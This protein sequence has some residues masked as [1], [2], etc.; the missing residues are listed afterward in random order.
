MQ[1]P[2][3]A[4]QRLI[5]ILAQHPDAFM[6][7]ADR[8]KA[9]D[10]ADPIYRLS[11]EE[12]RDI[13]LDGGHITVSDLIERVD[14]RAGRS[15]AVE[16]YKAL[17]E[18][19]SPAMAEGSLRRVLTSSRKRFLSRELA[20]LHEEVSRTD[21]LDGIFQRMLQVATEGRDVKGQVFDGQAAGDLFEQHQA[22]RRER[23][24]SI[25][26]FRT[27]FPAVD[28]H[29]GG[30]VPGRLTII[31][32]ASGHGKTAMVCNWLASISIRD[33]VPG[34]FASL[35][36]APRDVLDRMIAILSGAT[37]DTIKLGAV[38]SIIYQAIE[39][40]RAGALH[41]SD[42]YPRQIADVIFLA[43]RYSRT[44]GIRIFALDYAGELVRDTAPR[45]E[46]RDERFARWVKLVR[47]AAKRLSFHALV[48]CQ[49]NHEG[50]LA[51][52]K[53]MAH[54]AD[55]HLHFE[56][57]GSRHVLECRKNRF[58]PAGYRYAI[59]FNRDT[60]QMFEEGIERD[61]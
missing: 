43:E 39:D 57:Q 48:L 19:I 40:Y 27:G 33:K 3:E 6:Q 56:R 23:K 47:D 46:G 51:E 26:G 8:L 1:H 36:M 10:F 15:C 11:Y 17:E 50:L 49:V 61:A 13:Y 2:L 18:G 5:G 21:D 20:V 14:A 55:A 60:Q 45:D 24:S 9:E 25:E 53:K 42:N 30:L 16:L 32:G 59:R 34:F 22:E 44:H 28:A 41:I 31:S 35:E 29:L 7:T 54:L 52:S 37:L 4:E 58:G 12:L 38:N